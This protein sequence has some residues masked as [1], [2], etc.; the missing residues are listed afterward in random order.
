MHRISAVFYQK[1]ACKIV[2]AAVLLLGW[3][4]SCVTLSTEK[5]DSL[6]RTEAALVAQQ[7]AF[8]QQRQTFNL[9]A[10]LEIMQTAIQGQSARST[11]AAAAT[12][13]LSPAQMQQ[14]IETYQAGATLTAPPS[15]PAP[16][17]L[18]PTPGPDCGFASLSGR[19]GGDFPILEVV[20]QGVYNNQPEHRTIRKNNR[21]SGE[22]IQ[23]GCAVR[24]IF[25]YQQGEASTITGEVKD[26]VLILQV[27][28][29]VP[30]LNKIDRCTLLVKLKDPETI[31]GR[32]SNCD[33]YPFLF[34]RTAS[35]TPAP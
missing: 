15:V 34:R 24:G 14:V 20:S 17:S 6:R 5:K 26:G 33:Y 9:E 23:E 2:L 8:E 4:T 22:I 3:A 7:A 28:T 21:M 32:L 30:I 19:W 18:L 13:T 35:G 31:Q 27:S 1:A 11:E 12:P 16:T 25:H 10:T 29:L